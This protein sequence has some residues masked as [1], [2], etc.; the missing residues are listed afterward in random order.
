M[1]RRFRGRKR[2]RAQW[3]WAE[4]LFITA[5]DPGGTIGTRI[6]TGGPLLPE[7]R[8][9]WLCDT[10]KM[11]H[12]T[13]SAILLWVDA[14]A[15]LADDSAGGPSHNT[16]PPFEFYI[17]KSTLDEQG[18]AAQDFLPFQSPQVPSLVTD[19]TSGGE[20]SDGLD[21][22]LWTHVLSPFVAGTTA[23][24]LDYLGTGV[25]GA[26]NAQA[27][28]AS[29]NQSG[30]SIQ[31][32]RNVRMSWQPDVVIKT[33]RRLLRNEYLGFGITWETLGDG[34]VTGSKGVTI[35]VSVRARM[36]FA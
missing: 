34:P 36:L 19:W 9:K 10:R 1:T 31:Y 12:I 32:D 8:V 25:A 27:I 21:P 29:V 22:Y 30:A 7:G 17:I 23:T 14:L 4:S 16:I 15:Y 13:T 2:R 6:W 20:S 26:S 33:K 18:N 3:D 24:S 28:I 35:D 11:D 5:E